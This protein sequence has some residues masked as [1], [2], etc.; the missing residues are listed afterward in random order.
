MKL[1]SIV[2][3][4]LTVKPFQ[5]NVP[6]LWTYNIKQKAKIYDSCGYEVAEVESEFIAEEV[7]AILNHYQELTEC[8]EE[9][10]G[11]LNNVDFDYSRGR[12]ALKVCKEIY[13]NEPKEELNND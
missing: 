12:D 8:L 13:Y 11:I 7:A 4:E 10:V 6:V 3:G 5:K 9:A 1:N 2:S